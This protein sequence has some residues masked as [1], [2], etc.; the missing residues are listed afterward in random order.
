MDYVEIR[1]E[2]NHRHRN[3][4]RYYSD[5]LH[6]LNFVGA[7]GAAVR[8][9]TATATPGIAALRGDEWAAVPRRRDED[10]EEED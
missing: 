4:C 8:P 5:N 3:D 6:T 1:M 7:I 10:E 2:G 9:Q